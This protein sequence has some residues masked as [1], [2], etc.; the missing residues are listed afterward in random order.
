MVHLSRALMFGAAVL[1]LGACGDK[2]AQPAEAKATKGATQAQARDWRTAVIATP[3][4]GYRMGN[5]DARVKLVEYASFTCSHCRDFHLAATPVLK[6]ELVRSGQV[7]YEDRP[8][9]L[10]GPDVI[11]A[12]AAKCNGPDRFFPLADQLYRNH[13]QWVTP[14]TKLTEADLAPLQRLPQNQQIAAFANAAGF[15]RWAAVRGLPAAKL[16][17]C[18]TDQ[19]A[20]DRLQAVA[21]NAQTQFNIAGTPTFILNG[22]KVEGTDWGGLQPKIR[23]ALS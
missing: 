8:F 17:Q 22:E 4:G 7:S 20:A 16:N 15:N 12:L 18:L 3:E 23:A 10:N 1:A 2:G 11:A 5:P 9:I 14:F 6:D 21:Q 19:A 13:D